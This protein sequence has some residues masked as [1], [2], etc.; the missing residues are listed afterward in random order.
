MGA[1]DA[2]T[3]VPRQSATATCIWPAPARSSNSFGGMR[4]RLAC[5]S[6]REFERVSFKKTTLNGPWEFEV[7]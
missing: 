4:M 3:A 2:R 1:G 6:D 7:R 5:G